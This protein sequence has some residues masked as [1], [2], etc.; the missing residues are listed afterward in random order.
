[1]SEG[2]P[3]PPKRTPTRREGGFTLIEAMI[4]MAVLAFALLVFLS[5][6]TSVDSLRASAREESIATQDLQSAIEYTFGAPFDKFKQNYPSGVI[7]AGQVAVDGSTVLPSF[8][9]GPTNRRE[10]KNESIIVTWQDQD[11]NAS[12][13]WVEY[14]VEVTWTDHRG[15]PVRQSLVTRRSR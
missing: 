9:D 13:D 1:M 7:L 6:L 4:S 14:R 5:V 15:K 12:V 3:V 2:G 10:L 8:K 11:P